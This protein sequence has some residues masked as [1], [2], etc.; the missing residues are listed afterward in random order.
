[1]IWFSCKQCGK[2][3]SRSEGEAGTL[4]FCDCGGSARVPF[5]S[6]AAP[7]E[8]AA[9]PV[10]RPAPPPPP[11]AVP[12]ARA[13][14]VPVPDALPVEPVPLP[15][16]DDP[17]PLRKPERRYRKV[18]PNCCW[19][20]EDAPS[21]GRCVACHLPFCEG[22]LMTLRGQ[23]LCGPCKNF[24]IAG[25][26]QPSRTFPFAVVALVVALVAGPVALILSLVGAGVFFSEGTAGGAVLLNVLGLLLP[27]TAVVISGWSLRQLEAQSRLGGRGLAASGLCVSLVS[28]LWCL[29]VLTF[30]SFRYFR[31]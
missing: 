16:N 17:P 22:C 29:S 24:R 31:G 2:K 21:A 19:H 25:A 4:I 23:A 15:A 28:V 1:M 26:G 10:P 11:A 12:S 20:H 5:S 7:E 3:H 6:T 9:R 18:D 13:V 14:P 27:V 30:V 8:P